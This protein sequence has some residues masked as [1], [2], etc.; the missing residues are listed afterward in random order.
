MSNRNDEIE[1]LKRLRDKQ[2]TARDPQ[3][4]QRK[5]H[6]QISQKQKKHKSKK[7]GLKDILDVIPRKWLG[8]VIGGLLGIAVWVI[9]NLVAATAS[10]ADIA[11]LAAIVLLAIIGFIIGQAFDVRNELI[12]FAS[13]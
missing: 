4:Y 10:W 11:G 5:L 7:T 3:V 1:R 12:D 8:I 9:L 2:L 13:K 6:Q